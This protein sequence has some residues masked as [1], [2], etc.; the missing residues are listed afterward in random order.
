M[1]YV[2]QSPVNTNS[3][4]FL[5]FRRRRRLRDDKM[6]TT[7]T[8]PLRTNNSRPQSNNSHYPQPPFR[9]SLFVTITTSLSTFHKEELLTVEPGRV[10]QQRERERDHKRCQHQYHPKRHHRQ[11]RRH[12]HCHQRRLIQ[13]ITPMERIRHRWHGC[14]RSVQRW[15]HLQ[16]SVTAIN[17]E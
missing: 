7:P 17:G 1:N 11:Q 12:R 8:S 3:R 9:V 4:F 6:T 16:H 13:R 14:I 15:F 2:I 5:F 10:T